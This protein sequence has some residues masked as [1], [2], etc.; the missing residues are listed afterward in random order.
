PQDA[1]DRDLAL[2]LVADLDLPLA[3]LRVVD[4][5]ARAVAFGVRAQVLVLGVGVGRELASARAP[6]EVARLEV[7]RLLPELRRSRRRHRF[8]GRPDSTGRRAAE[9]E[10]KGQED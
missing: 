9:D 1:R 3:A 8:R 5:E 7:A 4:A 10:D 2:R 6:E